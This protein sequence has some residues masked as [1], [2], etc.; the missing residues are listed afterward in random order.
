M[1]TLTCVAII[2]AMAT[3]YGDTRFS[4]YNLRCKVNGQV[5]VSESPDTLSSKV[6]C[7]KDCLLRGCGGFSLSTRVSNT[8]PDHRH[9]LLTIDPAKLPLGSWSVYQPKGN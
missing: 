2:M 7:A 4:K 8:G 6:R 1:A 9:C 3:A 5:N